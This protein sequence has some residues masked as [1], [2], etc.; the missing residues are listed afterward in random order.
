MSDELLHALGDVYI[1]LNIA[2]FRKITFLQF[3]ESVKNN[4]DVIKYIQIKGDLLNDY[5]S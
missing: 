5:K 3:I 1:D 2:K 4:P